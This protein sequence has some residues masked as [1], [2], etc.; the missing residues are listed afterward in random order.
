MVREIVTLQIGN[1]ANNV[2]VHFWNQ[3]DIEQ[4]HQNTLIDYNTYFTFNQRT[5]L[6]SPRVLIIDYRNAFGNLL[7]ENE[8]THR[9]ERNDPSIEVIQRSVEKNSWSNRLRTRAKFHP[10]S[11]LPLVDYWYSPNPEENHFDI[12]PVGEQVFK[13][14]FDQTEHSLH[15]L[16]ES[17]DCL[18]SFRCLYDINNSFSGLF[19][20]IQDYLY[21][22]CPKQ[23]MWS[24]GLGNS[25]SELNLLS[26]LVH[27][28]NE[29]Q[30]PTVP[31][32]DSLDTDNLALA[33]QHSLISS[34]VTLD[35]LADR[36]CPMK[37][38]LLNLVWKI[39]LELKHRTLFYYLENS[40]NEN[41]FPMTNPIGCHYFLRG[42]QQK[43]LYDHALYNFNNIETS[44]DL[45]ATYLREQYSS[46]MFISTN[47]WT[48][49]YDCM[50]LLTGLINDNNSSFEFFDKLLIKMKKMNYKLLSKRWEENDFDEQM[51]EHLMNELSNMHEQYQLDKME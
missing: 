3:L 2:G 38:N 39:P 34:D 30:M 50:S 35:L 41:V 32:L 48:E 13:K 26:S 21:D 31:C 24:F 33:I 12:Y 1:Y 9:S 27:S 4:S 16:L 28:M 51:Y 46:K 42:I 36:L 23:P 45:I 40:A 49:K 15:Y 18:Q 37:K 5:N 7:D 22:E 29:N 19:T 11:L 10:K 17:C 14:M 43:Q 6:P 25:S 20:S 47:S 8:Y 44:A